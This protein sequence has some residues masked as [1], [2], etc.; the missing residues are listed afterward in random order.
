MAS[1]P[2]S[3][4]GQASKVAAS[5]LQGLAW[6]VLV[7]DRSGIIRYANTAATKSL[8]YSLEELIGQ[9]LK[10]LKAGELTRGAWKDF[11]R[12]LEREG[13]CQRYD[14]LRDREGKAFLVDLRL[15]PINGKG[16][17]IGGV[18]IGR[19]VSAPQV[20]PVRRKG[21]L[22]PR[23]KD[24][25]RLIGTGATAREIGKTLGISPRTV[26]VHRAHI[27]RKFGAR[28]LA[29]L[30]RLALTKETEL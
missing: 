4:T 19:L 21:Q 12:T 27:M 23:E 2:R 26:E 25:L 6:S 20:L 1:S 17:V 24:V 16:G 22:T 15:F 13:Y 30:V 7:I 18:G 11:L 14:W 29:D 10:A 3:K 8:G 9:P 5:A 28:R